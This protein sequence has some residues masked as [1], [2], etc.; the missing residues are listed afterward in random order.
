VIRRPK[1]ANPRNQCKCVAVHRSTVI[2]PLDFHCEIHV[3]QKE[4]TEVHQRSAL[5]PVVGRGPCRLSRRCTTCGAS[6]ATVRVHTSATASRSRVHA[7][8]SESDDTA[9]VLVGA[10]NATEVVESVDDG[11]GEDDV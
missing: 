7:C 5:A 4:K 11:A 10:G 9:G 3:C 8:A 1:R 6:A 2:Y